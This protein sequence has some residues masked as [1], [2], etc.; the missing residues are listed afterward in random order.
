MGNGGTDGGEVA[1]ACV[2]VDVYV[3]VCVYVYVSVREGSLVL[4]GCRMWGSRVLCYGP[5]PP[6]PAFIDATLRLPPLLC[7]KSIRRK[8]GGGEGQRAALAR[9]VSRCACVSRG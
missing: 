5:R 1:C 3:C 6:L 4:C 7:G 9:C 8:K 2:S